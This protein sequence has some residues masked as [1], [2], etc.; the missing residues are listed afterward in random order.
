MVTRLI[1]L[2]LFILLP[3]QLF[4]Q[5]EVYLVIGSDTGIWEGLD[6]ANFHHTYQLGL[7]TDPV[8]NAYKVMDPSFRN[9]MKDSYGTPLKMT[10]WMMSGNTFRYSVNNNVPHT[11]SL[12]LH[13][14]KKYHG[15]NV[16]LIGD[17]LSL[18]YH[19]WVWTDYD[20]DGKYYWNQALTFD[21][22]AEDFTYTLAENLL[23]EN[24]FPV[25]Y[26]SG[27]HYMNNEWQ[28]YLEN[29][30]PFSMHNDYPAKRT[31]TTEPLDNTYDWSLASS[32]FVPF[33]PAKDNYQIPGDLKG[34]DVRSEYMASFNQTLMNYVF[35]QAK[36]GIDQV[37]CIWAHLPEDDFLAN[38]KRVDSLAQKSAI[39]FPEVKFRYCTGVE[40]YQ[41]WLK[42]NDVTPPGIIL[43]EETSGD[44]TYYSVQ[45]D[46]P[47][48]QAFPFLAVKDLYEEYYSLHMQLIG[49]N[50]W[51]SI[52][53]VQKSMIVKVGVAV[54]D[55]LGN[56]STKIIKYLPD[57]IF[58][59]NTDSSYQEVYGNWISSVNSA[60]GNDSRS[61]S[62]NPNDSALVKF[63][64]VIPQSASYNMY[65]QSPVISTPPPNITITIKENGIDIFEK[66][67][68]NP[69][70]TNDWN[71]IGTISPSA[72]SNLS[73]EIKLKGNAASIT[74]FSA[75]V[76]KI[77]SMVREREI[78]VLPN[79]IDF[80]SFSIDDSAS[81]VLTI[82]NKGISE[83]TVSDITAASS[84]TIFNETFPIKIPGMESR[85]IQVK[86]F[87]SDLGPHTDTLFINSND[88]R[89]PVLSIL[90]TANIELPFTIVDNETVGSYVEF[91]EWFKSVAQAYG[92]SSRY[93][94][95]NKTPKSSAV[96]HTVLKHGGLYNIFEIVPRTVN[97]SNKAYYT[98][99]VD[100]VLK[101]SVYVD[102]NLGSGDW[103]KIISA[104]LP[105]DFLIELKVSDTGLNTNPNAVLRADAVKF[106][107]ISETTSLSE[108]YPS[109]IPNE[110]ILEQNYPNPFNPS[111]K[112]KY[113]I[114]TP[115]SS[116][117]LAKG[118]NEVRFVS[119]KVYNILGNEVATLVDDYKP[120]GSYEI[121]F[122]AVDTRHG[123][124]LPSGVYFY[125]LQVH[126]TKSGAGSFIQTRK[127][128]LIK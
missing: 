113:T 103:V 50:I 57:D 125:R 10:W 111:T 81:A 16:K 94:Y 60:W 112:I 95:L 84:Q 88:L 47:I 102:Q 1:F 36:K 2:A 6:V 13:L 116:S 30:L 90:C 8:R 46:E 69:L 42:T 39:A 96:F 99:S 107:L 105:K 24:M 108:E 54:T 9:Q 70:Q 104:E 53:P 34:Y 19:N 45:V 58:I 17:E 83:L 38:I 86:F 27:W 121:L 128:S 127:M 117:P 35:D 91:G 97:A 67:I 85:T 82:E 77:S 43:N 31:D 52:S 93:S 48:F 29:V 115:P 124:S 98:L 7:Y 55:T 40:A 126:S 23:E 61:I 12:P 87:A 41:R 79:I 71:F 73:I 68:V 75:D 76:I 65:F 78:S 26:R 21:E 66:N 118:R 20:N 106:S 114:P 4:S 101:D 62:L 100:G 5:G 37:V 49:N 18:H 44:E 59:D 109:L 122:D 63:L 25:S 110:A 64:Y 89:T 92:R 22:F 56:L 11:N 3:L 28:N 33:H 15:A 123:V 14:M 80:G 119:L 32:E 51:K 72:G 74:N 120:A